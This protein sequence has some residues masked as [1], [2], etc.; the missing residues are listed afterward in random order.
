M[1]GL[2]LNQKLDWRHW[3]IPEDSM[4]GAHGAHCT[5]TDSSGQLRIGTVSSPARA[6][7]QT[8]TDVSSWFL[9]RLMECKAYLTR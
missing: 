3:M 2:Y 5:I 7:G 4:D 9:Y 8:R 6:H 1:W